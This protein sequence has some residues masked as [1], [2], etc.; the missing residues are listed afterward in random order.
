MQ[1]CECLHVRN[2]SHIFT[3]DV[4]GVCLW[5]RVACV[6]AVENALD[7]TEESITSR[8]PQSSRRLIN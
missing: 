1:T 4:L 8:L 6:C 3:G 5:I 7:G 2:D